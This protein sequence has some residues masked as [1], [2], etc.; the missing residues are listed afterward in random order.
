MYSTID[1]EIAGP[2]MQVLDD[3]KGTHIV[4]YGELTSR[5]YFSLLSNASG[6]L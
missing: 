6:I 2:Y 5:S 1:L 4:R 3:W